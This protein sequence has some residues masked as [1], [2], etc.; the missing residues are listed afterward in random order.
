MK[1]QRSDTKIRA[2]YYSRRQF[3]KGAL[4]FGA[5][6]TPLRFAPLRALTPATAEAAVANLVW[7]PYLQS[8][9][10]SSVTV[11]WA[12]VNNSA[13][14]LRYHK[15][16]DPDTIVPAISQLI[17]RPGATPPYD[18]FF[19]QSAKLTDLVSGATYSY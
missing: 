8:S 9:T 5:G 12:T 11:A 2:P 13:S 19:I 6:L 17:T 3:L 1:K 7:G 18:N 4:A 10:T 16:S 15:G 14:E